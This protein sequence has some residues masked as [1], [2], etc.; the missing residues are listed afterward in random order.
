MVSQHDKEKMTQ[1]KLLEKAIKKRG[2]VILGGG[3]DTVPINIWMTYFIHLNASFFSLHSQGKQLP[4]AEEGDGRQ[5]PN[6]G[7][8]SQSKSKSFSPNH[9][10]GQAGLWAVRS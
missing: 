6:A 1:E 7:F 5:D 3:L 8:R 4:R 2:S 10:R 9:L